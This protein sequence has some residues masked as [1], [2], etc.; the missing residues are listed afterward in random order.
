VQKLHSDS[1]ALFLAALFLAALF[2]VL[3]K[4]VPTKIVDA[5]RNSILNTLS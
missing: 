3:I 1:A 2:L 5:A 4:K